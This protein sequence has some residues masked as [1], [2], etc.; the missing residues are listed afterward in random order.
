MTN[1]SYQTPYKVHVHFGEII[2]NPDELEERYHT[3][4]A[5]VIKEEQA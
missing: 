2:E 5:N 3:L 4:V 1:L